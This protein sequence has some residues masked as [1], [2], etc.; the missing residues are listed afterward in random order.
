MDINTLTLLVDVMH[1]GSFAA[2]ARHRDLD[3]SSV[4]RT[5][6]GLEDELGV[7]L[8]HRTTRQ[9][10]LTEAGQVYLARVEP[11]VHE[12][13]EARSAVKDV[14]TTPTGTL[15][16]TTSASCGQRL[17]VP[18][19]KDFR[20]LYPDLSIEMLLTDKYVDLIAER[21]DIAVRLGPQLDNGFV[22]VKLAQPRYYVCAAPDYIARTGAPEK[23][24]DL[25]Q[26][27]CLLLDLPDYR[28]RWLFRDAA[29]AGMT[30]PVH[31]GI[32]ISNAEALRQC[33]L[34][35]MGPA[36]LADWVVN[37]DLERG[38]LVD[39]F[40]GHRVAATEFGSA[41]WALY[42]SRSYLPLKVRVFLDYL[43]TNIGKP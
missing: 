15:R 28:S 16:M 40:P 31:G 36:L 14:S 1:Q 21:I 23:P 19:L 34:D 39:L 17:I 3:P 33:A 12:L 4:S 42:P 29:G 13:E 7:R 20:A 22:G 35:G 26:R 38:N 5:I 37:E 43:K 24:T 25:S 9:L 6:A 18:M 10:S 11:L 41:I 8:F 27:D 30:V 32:I 2:V